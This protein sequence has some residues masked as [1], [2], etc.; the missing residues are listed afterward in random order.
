M[1]K[2][3]ANQLEQVVAGHCHPDLSVG[4]LDLPD[5]EQLTVAQLAGEDHFQVPQ[6]AG[7]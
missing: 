2:S 4:L 5:V 3:P 1:G 6:R 7:Q